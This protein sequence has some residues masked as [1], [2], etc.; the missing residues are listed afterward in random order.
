MVLTQTIALRD[1]KDADA[2]SDDADADS[3]GLQLARPGSAWLGWPRPGRRLPCL[4]AWVPTCLLVGL[5]ARLPSYVPACL[6]ACLPNL[7]F[8]SRQR[9]CHAAF[10]SLCPFSQVLFAWKGSGFFSE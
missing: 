9:S 7:S 6:P 8:P 2:G 4:P 3:D 5:P 10:L 1:E